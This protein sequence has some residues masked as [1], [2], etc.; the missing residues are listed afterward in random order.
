[1]SLIQ[2]IFAAPK[3]L[4]MN[5]KD[6]SG[7]RPRIRKT[8]ERSKDRPEKSRFSKPYHKE[9]EDGR[10]PERKPY[11]S[12]GNKD[13]RPS[14]SRNTDERTGSDRSYSKP[15]FN[16]DRRRTDSKQGGYRER[17]SRGGSHEFE[18]PERAD[19]GGTDHHGKRSFSR[20]PA[21]PKGFER[22]DNGLIRLNKY[23][24]DSG[25]CSRREADKLIEAGAVTV[26]GKVV[27]QLGTKVNRDDKVAYG[28]QTLK[29]EVLRYVLLNKPKGFLTTA[30]DPLDRK[31]VME[32]VAKACDERIYPVGRLDRNTLGL[33]LLT[34]DGEL[35]KKLTHPKYGVKKL[36]HVTLDKAL[37]KNDLIKIADGIELE[38]GP[39]KADSIA[40]VTGVESKK[41]VGIELHSGRNRIVRRIFESLGYKV[42]K[43]D[44]VR[45]ASLTKINLPRGHWRHL[46]EKEVSMLKMLK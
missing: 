18:H 40:W 39:I 33:L 29:R 3:I 43:L 42:E 28:G 35:A 44:R 10:K 13:Q 25:V 16:K 46:S 34:N 32:L 31:T 11:K 36:Y 38:D 15:Q 21:T 27:T 24:A 20:K 26:N 19:R 6:Q 12:A 41:E 5:S 45:F 37:T 22:E 14:N 2:T 17:P 7:K 4:I 23:L 9:E 8:D 30:D 1:M